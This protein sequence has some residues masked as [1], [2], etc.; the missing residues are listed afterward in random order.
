MLEAVEVEPQR[1]LQALRIGI[2]IHIGEAV[3]GTVG[4]P[5]RKEYTV[6]GDT[7]DLAAR[8]EQLTKET[9]SRL[10]VSDSVHEAMRVTGDGPRHRPGPDRDPW[11]RRA[12]PGHG[13]WHNGIRLWLEHV[14]ARRRGRMK[15]ERIAMGARVGGRLDGW[16]LTFDKCGADTPGRRRRPTS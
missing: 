11:L 7:V 5:Q 13:G 1:P 8:L 16:R 12:G 10:L 15:P 4:S 6:I 9:A 14:P 2:G 3:T